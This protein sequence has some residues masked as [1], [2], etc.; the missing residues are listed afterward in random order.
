MDLTFA[1]QHI[2]EDIKDEQNIEIV[3]EIFNSIQ[4]DIVEVDEEGNEILS[5]EQV[6]AKEQLQAIGEMQL[7][8]KWI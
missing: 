8:D 3:F 5:P 1:W 7:A 6:R 2:Q 4:G